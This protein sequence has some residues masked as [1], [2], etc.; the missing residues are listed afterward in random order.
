MI[1]IKIFD[2]KYILTLHVNYLLYPTILTGIPVMG[3]LCQVHIIH[4]PKTCQCLLN[5]KEENSNL[6]L[7]KKK[8]DKNLII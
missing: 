3:P 1:D 4:V 8:N 2:N 5:H 6:E 7:H